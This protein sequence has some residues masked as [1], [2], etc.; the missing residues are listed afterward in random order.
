MRD[1]ILCKERRGKILKQGKKGRGVHIKNEKFWLIFFKKEDLGAALEHVAVQ[2]AVLLY[3]NGKFVLWDNG[4]KIFLPFL[5][6]ERMWRWY[7]DGKMPEDFWLVW[8]ASG[9]GYFIG[10]KSSGI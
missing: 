4:T 2:G 6:F 8:G 7:Q 5:T 10:K 3:E 9:A 1:E